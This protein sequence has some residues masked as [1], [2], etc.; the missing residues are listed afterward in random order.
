MDSKDDEEITQALIN[1]FKAFGRA[2]IIVDGIIVDVDE[3][4]FTCTVN[5]KGNIN[6]GEVDNHFTKVPLKVLKGSQASLIEIPQ[7]NSACT[8]CFKD[9]NI[10]RPQLYQA[11]VCDKVL[12]KI[13]DQTL[14][15]SING[16][17]FNEGN[18]GGIV[19]LD[20]LHNRIK[21]VEDFTNN[22]LSTL[23]T[24]VVPLAPSGTY[25]FSGVFGSISPITP[26]SKDDLE[27]VKVKH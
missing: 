18:F 22:L 25:P 27:D 9:N 26:G 17:V 19:K 13:G 4:D 8:L 6:G 24:V 3:T 1:A 21:A 10:Q 16:F 12:V 5:V 15:I 14:N 23:K 7:P 11:H 2:S 20:P